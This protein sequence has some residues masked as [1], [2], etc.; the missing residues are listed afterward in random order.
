MRFFDGS[1]KL[2]KIV[3]LK[4]NNEDDEDD[5]DH[6]A[7]DTHESNGDSHPVAVAAKPKQT[8]KTKGDQQTDGD[9]G[10]GG[11]KKAAAFANSIGDWTRQSPCSKS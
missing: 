11:I 6:G 2:I 10:V 8:A 5:I 3:R 1:G 9:V 7:A 4:T